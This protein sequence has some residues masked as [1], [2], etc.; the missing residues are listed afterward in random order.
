MYVGLG[1]AQRTQDHHHTHCSITPPQLH[2][3]RQWSQGWC[4]TLC[5]LGHR[6]VSRRVSCLNLHLYKLRTFIFAHCF[7][8]KGHAARASSSYLHP[9]VPLPPKALT[10]T[11]GS[12]T[13]VE[14]E[15]QDIHRSGEAA[16]GLLGC[17]RLSQMTLSCHI[18][19]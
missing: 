8:C 5:A 12:N 15:A 7:H 3:P 19:V 1:G 10:A 4:R 6:G 11:C 2:P 14:N 9:G 13:E 17:A 18:Y 16:G